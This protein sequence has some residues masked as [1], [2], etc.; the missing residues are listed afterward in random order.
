MLR[1]W[2][3]WLVANRMLF[4]AAFTFTFVGV[5]VVAT[6]AKGVF[7]WWVLPCALA[8]VAGGL[9]SGWMRRTYTSHV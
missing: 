7:G 1:R 6:I 8:G 5:F 2:H 9:G 3:S 4:C